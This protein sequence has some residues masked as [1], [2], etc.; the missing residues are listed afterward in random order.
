MAYVYMRSYS[1][2]N[3]LFVIALPAVSTNNHVMSFHMVVHVPIVVIY[4][5]TPVTIPCTSIVISATSIIKTSIFFIVIMIA[6]N[7]SDE[8]IRIT[9]YVYWIVLIIDVITLPFTT[10]GNPRVTTAVAV[11]SVFFIVVV[12]S[13]YATYGLPGR[14]LK[15]MV[16]II[17]IAAIVWWPRFRNHRRCYNCN[18]SSHKCR[19][20]E[21]FIHAWS[22]VI[23][24]RVALKTSHTS[25][26]ALWLTQ[27][28]DP[29]RS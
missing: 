4:W 21:H 7:S 2:I 9:L 15:I 25:N 16:L 24:R 6:L 26:T 8:I 1:R 22:H 17:L 5:S 3:P 20:V 13:G 11:Y 23:Y 19:P 12:M 18:S 29:D 28:T 27:P 14:A 10:I